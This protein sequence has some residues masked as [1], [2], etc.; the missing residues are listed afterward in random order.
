MGVG[1]GSNTGR[2]SFSMRASSS[3]GR[4]LLGQ[5]RVM[6]WAEWSNAF[7][8]HWPLATGLSPTRTPS[9]SANRHSISTA[10]VCMQQVTVWRVQERPWVARL[11]RCSVTLPGAFQGNCCH[12]TSVGVTPL[13]CV[14]A[15]MLSLPDHRRQTPSCVQCPCRSGEPVVLP[16]SGGFNHIT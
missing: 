7:T 8:H 6:W 11:L 12:S 1:P 4:V 2:S 15:C 5:V 14:L 13:F 10:R 16:L 3:Y 9:P